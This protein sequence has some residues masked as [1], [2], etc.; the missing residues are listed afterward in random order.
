MGKY[1][2][3]QLD[4]IGFSNDVRMHISPTHIFLITKNPDGKSV[5]YIYDQYYK[6]RHRRET[7]AD[8][9]DMYMSDYNIFYG[10]NLYISTPNMKVDHNDAE[11]KQWIW[12]VINE[13]NIFSEKVYLYNKLYI[14][15]KTSKDTRITYKTYLDGKCSIFQYELGTLMYLREAEIL[16]PQP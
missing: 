3:H 4:T 7:T 10:D 8:I 2:Q 15:L 5:I 16:Q 13:D 11:Y 14:G 6:F 12:T 9:D 1:I